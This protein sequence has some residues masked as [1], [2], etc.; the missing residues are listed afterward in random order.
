[1]VDRRHSQTKPTQKITPIVAN[2]NILTFDIEEWAIEIARVGGPR[3]HRMEE[4]DSL[5]GQVLDLLEKRNILATFFCTGKMALEFPSVVKGIASKGHEIACHSFQHTWCN[6]MNHHALEEDTYAAINAIEQCIGK[7]VKGYRAPAFSIGENNTYAFEI[8]AKNGI[9][10]D[11]S[12]FPAHRDF[13][14]FPT[15]GY[16]TPVTI[17]C[18]GVQVHEFPIPLVSVFGQRVAYS[19]GGYF[20]L[21]PLRFVQKQISN[22]SYTM[23]YF[24]IGDLVKEPKPIMSKEAY[25]IYFKEP[26]TI[27]NRVKRYIK[28]NIGLGNAKNKATLLIKQNTFVN[29]EQADKQLNWQKAPFVQL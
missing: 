23:T 9:E 28:S 21:F 18:N 16:D 20:R 2:M 7:K 10:Y 1:M 8:L 4:Y 17:E 6:K 11:S 19:G 12:V 15:F 29:I 3:P 14:G 24:H 26:G 13:G 22:S 27:T 25:E 5:L